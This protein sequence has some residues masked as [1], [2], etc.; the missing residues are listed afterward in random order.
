MVDEGGGGTIWQQQTRRAV[1][2]A[3][4]VTAIESPDRAFRFGTQI[5]WKPRDIITFLAPG[6]KDVSFYFTVKAGLLFGFQVRLRSPGDR[7]SQLRPRC[8]KNE[9]L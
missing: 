4:G 1:G 3:E 5:F 9:H 6:I 2:G 7:L 8:P